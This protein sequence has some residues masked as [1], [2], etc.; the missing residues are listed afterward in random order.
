MDEDLKIQ[1][2]Q[3]DIEYLQK[4]GYKNPQDMIASNELKDFL[5]F[6]NFY[7]IQRSQTNQRFV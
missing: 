6:S 7:R 5:E 3:K 1:K 4:F 2:N